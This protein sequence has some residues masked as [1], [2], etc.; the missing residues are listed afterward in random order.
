M[1][2]KGGEKPNIIPDLTEAEF[3]LRAPDDKQVLELRQRM[4][5]VF[6]GAAVATGCQVELEWGLE[7]SV[8]ANLVTNTPMA[9]LYRENAVGLGK[10]L[11]T[12]E[13]EDKI[14]AMGG[15]TDMGNISFVIP[16][17]HPMFAIP[18]KYGN[19]TPGFTAS[20]ATDEA[21]AQAIIAGKSMAMTCLDLFMTD[22]L[23]EEA[24]K[25]F[26]PRKLASFA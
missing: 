20:A 25:A 4:V 3:Y 16:T 23:L 15:S 21:H 17:I 8:Y 12:K 14:A 5:G 18:S 11:R 13:E 2:S 9:H 6:Q 24:K 7:R 26:E 10:R 22:G 19:H 1:I